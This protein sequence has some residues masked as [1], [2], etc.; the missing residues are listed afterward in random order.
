MNIPSLERSHLSVSQL[1]SYLQ[2]PRKYF[3]QYIDCATPA[4]RSIALTFG[5]AW[6]VAI[7]AYL[8]N[9]TT[10][11]EATDLFRDLLSTEIEESEI[12]VLF[13]DEEDLGACIDIGARTID[14]FIARVPR[15][16]AVLG[17]EVPFVLDLIPTEDGEEIPAPL[18]GSIDAVVI[19][20]DVVEIWELKTAKR[21]WS[22]D[23]LDYDLQTTAYRMG[24]RERLDIPN[25]TLKL[26][27]ATK[28]KKPEV[29]VE[30]VIRTA[31]DEARL[32]RLASSVLRAIRAGVDHPIQTW[33]CRGC[34]FSTICT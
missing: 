1:K 34:C 21:R 22:R 3:Y 10:T 7:G 16:D 31:L 11:E 19:D 26:L 20:N 33:A 6:H 17:I 15:P 18:I 30:A 24:A 27:I 29:Q 8:V 25:A 32:A 4:F 23:Q 5:S 13:D 14:T 2:C 12:P 28:T 9:G